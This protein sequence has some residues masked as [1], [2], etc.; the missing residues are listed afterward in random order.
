MKIAFLKITIRIFFLIIP[1]F[2]V[3]CQNSGTVSSI[4]IKKLLPEGKISFEVL[5]SVETTARQTELSYKMV[6]AFQ[7]NT[8]AFVAYLEKIGKKQ[9]AKYPKNKIMSEAEFLEYMDFAKN[10][11]L[12]PSR[13]EIVEVI[14]DDNRISFKSDGQL[15]EIFDKITY[16]V[17]TNTFDL[18][19]RYTLKFIDSVSIETNTNAFKETWKGYNWRFE[20]P[21][22][23]VEIPTKETISKMSMEQYKIT[24]GR[25]SSGKTF[26]I[27][28]LKDVQEGNWIVR[29]E[30]TIRMK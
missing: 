15:A 18:A 6:E 16:H 26:M 24:L 20:Y 30:V 29:V 9:K 21:K 19:N 22:D 25:L 1:A 14:Y 13:I 10:I 3:F 5:D 12:L 7:E 8:D 11:K 28:S 23:M 4:E 2:S 17:E 27:I